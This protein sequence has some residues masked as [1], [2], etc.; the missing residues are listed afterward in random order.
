M[1]SWSKPEKKIQEKNE[2]TGENFF[3]DLIDYNT[4]INQKFPIK[5]VTD[6]VAELN[7]KSQ[8]NLILNFA[9]EGGPGEVFKNV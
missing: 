1:L 6:E 7:K 3:V 2:V 5:D 4:Y 9:Q 8:T